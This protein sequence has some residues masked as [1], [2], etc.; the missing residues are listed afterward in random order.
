MHALKY[1]S[2]PCVASIKPFDACVNIS[3]KKE[4]PALNYFVGAGLSVL[5]SATYD[6]NSSV[7]L[8]RN[9]GGRRRLKQ[10][11]SLR[12]NTQNSECPKN[13]AFIPL[14]GNRKEYKAYCGFNHSYEIQGPNGISFAKV[15]N[16]KI[17]FMIKYFAPFLA[18][19]KQ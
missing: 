12:R 17:P 5:V 7:F 10:R 2:M 13:L 14:D 19:H 1:K 18:L 15:K 4:S 6:N 8:T 16:I 11:E 3:Q 9:A